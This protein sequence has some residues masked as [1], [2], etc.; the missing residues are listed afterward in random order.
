MTK[1]RICANATGLP[2]RTFL[3]GAVAIPATCAAPALAMSEPQDEIS[4]YMRGFKAGQQKM[5]EYVRE[6]VDS[7]PPETEEKPAEKI[8]RLAKEMSAA[9]DQFADDY[10]DT[11]WQLNMARDDLTGS[12]SALVRFTGYEGQAGS[13]RKFSVLD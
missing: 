7:I 6:V 13:R 11:E 8:K 12:H 3:A 2:R 5:V 4:V 1:D 10:G 9:L